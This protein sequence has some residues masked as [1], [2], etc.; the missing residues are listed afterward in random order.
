MPD[1][2]TCNK[3]HTLLSPEYFNT[4][5]MINCPACEVLLRIDVFPAFF[6]GITPGKTGEAL[7]VDT[8][9]SCFYHPQK[10][11][12]IPC[13]SCGR[14]LCAMC[15][16]K[17]NNQHLCPACL[18]AGRK[19]GKLKHLENRRTL[20]DAIALRLSLYPVAFL[21]FWFLTIITAPMSIFIAIRYWNAPS[22]LVP[23][24]TKLWFVIAILFSSLQIL[25]WGLLI[26]Q[27]FVIGF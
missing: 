3:C 16:I 7:L 17:L 21:V 12:V 24:R 26:W 4:P 27:I 10:K 25:G 9:A 23:R 14:F 2:I 1:A 8:E 18:E 19:K 11:A 22:S 15:D 6:K 20:Y 13:D 5:D